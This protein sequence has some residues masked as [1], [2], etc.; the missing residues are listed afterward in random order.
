MNAHGMQIHRTIYK[1]IGGHTAYLRQTGV[2]EHCT[3]FSIILC[4][5]TEYDMWLHFKI[6]TYKHVHCKSCS[7]G[8]AVL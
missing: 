7:K 1:C 5:S 3:F 8:L 2:S 6:I 4:R